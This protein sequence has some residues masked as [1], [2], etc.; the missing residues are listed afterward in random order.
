[1]VKIKESELFEPVKEWLEEKGY[2]VF[3]EVS[4]KYSGG[5]RADIIGRNSPAIAIVE[6]KTTLSLELLDQAYFWKQ[7][8][9][10]IYVAIPRRTKQVPHIIR[11]FLRKQGIG[12]L[13]VDIQT[14][15]VNAWEK[16]KFNRPVYRID[17]GTEL[18]QEHKTWLKGGSAGGG[19]VTS[20]KLTMEK[21]KLLLKR[22]RERDQR[23]GNKTDGWL[24]L[25]KILEHCETHYA[26][27]KS[28]LSQALRNFESDWCECKY[29][30][31]RVF[32]RY[33]E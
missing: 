10:Y 5:K 9:H 12:L 17:W 1:M 23:E 28:S 13:L 25:N 30:G 27:P 29:E 8:G 18:H 6:L 24:S 4:P 14:G 33:I 2:E 19:Y 21:V 16:A 15:C 31:G 3:S 26:Q 32:F 22:I 7:L 20:Y 11:E